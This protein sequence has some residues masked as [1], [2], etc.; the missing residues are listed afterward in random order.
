MTI[1]IQKPILGRYRFLSATTKPTLKNR[2]DAGRNGTTKNA[3]DMVTSLKIITYLQVTHILYLLRSAT[4]MQT[5]SQEYVYR[6]IEDL[7]TACT[8]TYILSISINMM[9]K[10][11]ITLNIRYM[12]KH[13]WIKPVTT[14]DINFK[15]LHLT[16]SKINFLV[17]WNLVDK[18]IL[19][20]LFCK[21]IPYF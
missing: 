12:Q 20:M 7:H 13:D 14:S 1:S 4:G 19:F 3:K 2:F 15:P 9:M 21:L 17:W 10:S 6:L 16:G 5:G 8:G 11:F 18:N